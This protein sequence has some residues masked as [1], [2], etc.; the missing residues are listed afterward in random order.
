MNKA[1]VVFSKQQIYKSE[2]G[3][4]LAVPVLPPWLW[5]NKRHIY[6]WVISVLPILVGHLKHLLEKKNTTS[7]RQA[8]DPFRNVENF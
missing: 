4:N 2:I 6:D 7:A 1:S 8:S 3:P 5:K